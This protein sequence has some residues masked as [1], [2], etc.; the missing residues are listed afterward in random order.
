MGGSGWM[1]GL[2]VILGGGGGDD[3]VFQTMLVCSLFLSLV[4]DLV[5]WFVGAFVDRRLVWLG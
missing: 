1:D 4:D 2:F 5:R 3:V